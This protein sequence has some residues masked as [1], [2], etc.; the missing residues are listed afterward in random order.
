MR[1]IQSIVAFSNIEVEYM[2]A[3][4]A[5]KEVVWLQILCSGTG[6]VQQVVR[7]DCDIQCAIFLAKKP[8]YH[9]KTKHIDI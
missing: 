4:L 2:E 7:I 9:S 6:L 8:T 3:T 1:K 5:R